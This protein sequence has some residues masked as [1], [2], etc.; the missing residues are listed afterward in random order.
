MS[1]YINLKVVNIVERIKHKIEVFYST[2]ERKPFYSWIVH[3]KVYSEKQKLA[4]V[5]KNSIY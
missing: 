1:D 5:N 3:I 2:D 4:I